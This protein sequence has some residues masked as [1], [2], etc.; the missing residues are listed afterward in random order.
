[1]LSTWTGC[2]S[3]CCQL[4]PTQGDVGEVAVKAAIA[5][6]VSK[7][8]PK[9][10]RPRSGRRGLAQCPRKVALAIAA[11]L[12]VPSALALSRLTFD[13]RVAGEV[14]HLFAASNGRSRLVTEADLVGFP[15]RTSAGCAGPTSLARPIRSAC[16]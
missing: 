12:A 5:V 15:S 13:W 11:L 7:A 16:A 3:S 9:R 10:R 2:L 14:R 4:A 6:A 8:I 1:M